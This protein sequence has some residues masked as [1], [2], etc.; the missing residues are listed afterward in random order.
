MS[1]LCVVTQYFHV[2]VVL[3][4]SPALAVR[5]PYTLVPQSL[6]NF[7]YQHKFNT[8]F[9]QFL[10]LRC[11]MMLQV[12]LTQL[13]SSRAVS[14]TRPHSHIRMKNEKDLEDKGLWRI[15]G[16]KVWSD[17]HF[18]TFTSGRVKVEVK[19]GVRQDRLLQRSMQQGQRG[20]EGTR[21]AEGRWHREGSL[22]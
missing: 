21:Q 2:A 19:A 18:R 6:W 3:W 5:N 11:C 7:P 17:I 8:F 12:H 15:L 20:E 10:T 13:P 1:L 22:S 9:K 16:Q 14:T 4:M